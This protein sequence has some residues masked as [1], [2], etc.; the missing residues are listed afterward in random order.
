LLKD[1]QLLMLQKQHAMIMNPADQASAKQ[2]G[3][4]QQV[5]LSPRDDE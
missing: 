2:V 4:L 1:I 5:R 3:I